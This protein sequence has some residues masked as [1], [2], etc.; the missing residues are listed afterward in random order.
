[1]TFRSVCA[2]AIVAAPLVFAACSSSSTSSDPSNSTPVPTGIIDLNVSD[3]SDYVTTVD[4]DTKKVT[5]PFFG[6]APDR[7]HDGKLVYR[8]NSG[9]LI[10]GNPDGTGRRLIVKQNLD[11][12]FEDHHDDYFGNPRASADGKYVAYEGIGGNL[13]VVDRLNG[14]VIASWEYS[15]SNPAGYRC[16]SW[17]STGRLIVQGDVSLN[18]GLYELN[19][20]TKTATPIGSGLNKPQYPNVSGD[21]HIAF[22]MNGYVY[23][24]L[25]DGSSSSLK[26]LTDSSITW[27]N[28]ARFPTWSPDSKFVAVYANNSTVKLVPFVSGASIVDIRTFIT[29]PNVQIDNTSTHISWR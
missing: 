9:D 19:I 13:Y 16:P 26:Q 27:I 4:L 29:D 11:V 25:L 21:G 24:M 6:Y 28:T 2:I 17:S 12:P 8:D 18:P 23:T 10:E 22:V 1:M 3:S 14:N 15:G 5:N 20:T 7:T